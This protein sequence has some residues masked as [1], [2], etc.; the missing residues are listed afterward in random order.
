MSES[1]AQ[2]EGSPASYT[3]N[4]ER[5]E[6]YLEPSLTPRLRMMRDLNAR[7]FM[8]VGRCNPID[9]PF[10]LHYLERYQEGFILGARA[11][12]LKDVGIIPK[13]PD[14]DLRAILGH[15][16]RG[17]CVEVGEHTLTVYQLRS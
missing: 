2:V 12:G 11:E 10:P 8:L 9:C 14:L 16:I 15:L 5:G 6:T 1:Q 17:E 7:G 13:Y 4:F 3:R